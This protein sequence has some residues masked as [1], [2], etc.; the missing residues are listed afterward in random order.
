MPRHHE[1]DR[2]LWCAML[3]KALGQRGERHR[4]HAPRQSPSPPKRV[5]IRERIGKCP[6]VPGDGR[7]PHVGG[8]PRMCGRLGHAIAAH[9]C[10]AVGLRKNRRRR[11]VLEKLQPR[12]RIEPAMVGRI[13]RAV[14]RAIR[15]RHG[16]PPDGGAATVLL[17]PPDVQS[18]VT[19][20]VP[21]SPLHLRMGRTG[22]E[23]HSDRAP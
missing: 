13:D 7:L 11:Y 19:A 2:A 14:V 15:S 22:S 10:R 4:V 16:T 17:N 9:Q 12:L 1:R 5:G 20:G 21:R 3:K 8:S 6:A 18:R 23:R